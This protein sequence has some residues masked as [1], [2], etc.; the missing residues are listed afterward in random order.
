MEGLKEEINR[1]YR[2]KPFSP[3]RRKDRKEIQGKIKPPPLTR[4]EGLKEESCV[5]RISRCAQ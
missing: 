5:S 3:Q 2:M 1:I 4:G